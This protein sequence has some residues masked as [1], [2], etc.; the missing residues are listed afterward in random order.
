[1]AYQKGGIVR[2]GENRIFTATNLKYR[3][4][5]ATR[6]M[7]SSRAPAMPATIG[8]GIPP[9]LVVGFPFLGAET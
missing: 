4:I 7:S 3:M 6:M 1:M 2:E 9:P 8:N 5:M